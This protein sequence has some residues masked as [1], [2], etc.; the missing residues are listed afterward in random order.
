MSLEIR[1]RNQGQV[2]Q[3]YI[4][5]CFDVVMQDLTPF[6]VEGI[7]GV[8]GRAAVDHLPA[9]AHGIKAPRRIRTNGAV[10]NSAA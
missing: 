6:S 4:R 5:G 1:V 2:L 3:S 9:I 8:R 7:G 10:L